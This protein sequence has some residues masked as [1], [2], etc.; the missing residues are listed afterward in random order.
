MYGLVNGVPCCCGKG[1]VI[2][3]IDSP[4]CLG[5]EGDRVVGGRGESEG[6]VAAG[7]NLMKGGLGPSRS[8]PFF[9][10]SRRVFTPT[11]AVKG[12][13]QNVVERFAPRTSCGL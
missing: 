5:V 6:M 12:R 9:S 13:P 11:A 1:I 7:A 4:D 2:P 8:G 3:P 10:P